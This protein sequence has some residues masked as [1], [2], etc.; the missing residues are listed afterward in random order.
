MRSTW[1]MGEGMFRF[2]SIAKKWPMAAV[3]LTRRSAM[4]DN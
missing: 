1:P 3:R 4:A 2:E